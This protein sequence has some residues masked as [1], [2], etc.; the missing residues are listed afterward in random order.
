MELWGR[1]VTDNSGSAVAVA[2]NTPDGDDSNNTDKSDI[3]YE[4]VSTEKK[5]QLKCEDG[6][7]PVADGSRCD[8]EANILNEKSKSLR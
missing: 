3:S 7:I 1:G 5:E 2:S 4:V 6:K 8:T